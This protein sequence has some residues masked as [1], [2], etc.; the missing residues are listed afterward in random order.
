[1]YF[2]MI[3]TKG[4]S[5]QEIEDKFAKA[6][7][8]RKVNQELLRDWNSNQNAINLIQSVKL[9]KNQIVNYFKKA[10]LI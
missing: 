6:E 3:E 1:M 9:T 2:F 7:D 10:K 8:Q 5:P 4:L